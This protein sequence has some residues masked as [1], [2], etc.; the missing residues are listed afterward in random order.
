[1]YCDLQIV[2][3]I[4]LWVESIFTSYRQKE[5][6]GSTCRPIDHTEQHTNS[7]NKYMTSRLDFF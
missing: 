5:I 3:R 2:N 6:N 7:V 4:V 1:M